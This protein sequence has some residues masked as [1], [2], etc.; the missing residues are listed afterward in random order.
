[1]SRV[2][3]C[4]QKGPRG[5]R[6]RWLCCILRRRATGAAVRVRVSLRVREICR[7]PTHRGRDLFAEAQPEDRGQAAG[8]SVQQ[9]PQQPQHLHL[10]VEVMVQAIGGDRG[11]GH[12]VPLGR[13]EGSAGQRSRGRRP[14]DGAR[15]HTRPSV[16]RGVRS[17]AR[18]VGAHD[19]GGAVGRVA[20]RRDEGGGDAGPL[21][22]VQTPLVLQ[23]ERRNVEQAPLRAAGEG[24]E[25][26]VPQQLRRDAEGGGDGLEEAGDGPARRPP[27]GVGAVRRRDLRVEELRQPRRAQRGAGGRGRLRAAVHEALQDAGAVQ[28]GLHE[29]VGLGQ[30]LDLGGL[31]RDGGDWG[32]PVVSP[33]FGRTQRERA[34]WALHLAATGQTD[35]GCG[36]ADACEPTDGGCWPTDT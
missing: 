28:Q 15:G 12:E 9:S 29:R 24:E 16:Q 17:A 2:W 27:V 3:T 18:G 10:G 5:R 7:Q 21:Q 14:G 33:V 31:G 34:R 23:H 4:L 13:V 6:W 30:V 11:P 8:E 36:P 1:M 26:V 22:A 35:G 32:R 19:R 25:P 20:Q